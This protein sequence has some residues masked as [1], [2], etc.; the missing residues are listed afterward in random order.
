MNTDNTRR[1]AGYLL[2]EIGLIDDRYIAE[3]ATAYAPARKAFSLRQGLI[4]AATLTLVVS[5]ATG[6]FI[7]G[8][9]LIGLGGAKSAA[10][11]DADNAYMDM[12]EEDGADPG[13]AEGDTFVAGSTTDVPTLSSRLQALKGTTEALAVSAGEINLSGG[14]PMIIWQYQNETTYRVKTVT[15]ADYAALTQYLPGGT[16]LDAERGQAV[17]VRVW[18]A[19][20]DGTVCSPYLAQTP[21]NTGSGLFDY[22][23]EQEPSAAFAQLLCDL[24]SDS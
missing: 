24:L 11:E 14:A 5:V 15:E 10:P 7:G 16:P 22:V 19:K 3:A 2:D 17:G 12:V 20:G 6:L 18:L 13:D 8:G 23:P 21:D 9:L 1:L 4:L